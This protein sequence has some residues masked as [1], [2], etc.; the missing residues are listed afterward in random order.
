MD[1]GTRAQTACTDM[2]GGKGSWE[3]QENEELKMKKEMVKKE[4]K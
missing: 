4:A 3:Q 1:K 2:Q